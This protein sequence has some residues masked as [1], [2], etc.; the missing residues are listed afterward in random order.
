MNPATRSNSATPWSTRFAPLTTDFTDLSTGGAITSWSWDFGD[1][2][3]ST[4]QNP[5]HTYTAAGTYTV[6]LTVTG[7]GGADTAIQ[8]DLVEVVQRRP[9]EHVSD[10]PLDGGVRRLPGVSIFDLA[11]LA[12]RAL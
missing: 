8:L 12:L 4:A 1:A 6:S 7:P 2:T 10:P 9:F 11:G 5:G 3:T